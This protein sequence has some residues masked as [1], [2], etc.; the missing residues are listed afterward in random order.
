MC[1]VLHSLYLPFSYINSLRTFNYL[2]GNPSRH[3]YN[4]FLCPGLFGITSLFPFRQVLTMVFLTALSNELLSNILDF[5]KAK[6][7]IA[8]TRLVN[9]QLC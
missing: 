3:D 9:R 4:R 7:D 2:S 8:N 1:A 5:L 6:L